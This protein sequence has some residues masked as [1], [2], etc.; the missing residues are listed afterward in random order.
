MFSSFIWNRKQKAARHSSVW[1][2]TT[3][4][5]ILKKNTLIFFLLQYAELF[6]GA[7]S[8]KYKLIVKMAFGIFVL[9]CQFFFFFPILNG[10]ILI[11]TWNRKLSVVNSKKEKR[12]LSLFTTGY[13]KAKTVFFEVFYYKCWLITYRI[14]Q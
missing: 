7:L 8:R 4:V 6:N 2:V 11:P 14:I 10:I 9:Q 12:I 1:T 3:I 5:Y 13:N